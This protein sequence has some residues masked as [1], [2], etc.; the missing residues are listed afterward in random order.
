MSKSHKVYYRVVEMEID[1]ECFTRWDPISHPERAVADCAEAFEHSDYD[2]DW[3]LTFALLNDDGSESGRYTVE[4][5][6]EP[7]FSVVKK[8]EPG[9]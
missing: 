2:D 3:P 8:D 4:M 9:E 1:D 7:S 5:E 6:W